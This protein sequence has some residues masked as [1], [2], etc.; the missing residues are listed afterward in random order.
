MKTPPS[1]RSAVLPTGV[2][3]PRQRNSELRSLTLGLV[4]ER[5]VIAV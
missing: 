2:G 4:F 1:A 3:G 5:K